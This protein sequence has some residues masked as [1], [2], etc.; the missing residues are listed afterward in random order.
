MDMSIGV[1]QCVKAAWP[2]LRDR[3]ITTERAYP[4]I[5]LEVVDL[6]SKQEHPHFLAHKFDHIQ[7]VSE[8]HTVLTDPIC[9]E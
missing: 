3:E 2:R 8:S 9:I 6:L 4:V 7:V 1:S 5:R